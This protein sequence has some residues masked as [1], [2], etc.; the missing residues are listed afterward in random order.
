ML[1]E[2]ITLTGTPIENSLTDLW[3]QINFVNRGLLGNFNYFKNEF[4]TPIEK[5]KNQSQ[6]EKLKSLIHPFVLRRT[7]DQ[8]AK[9][10]P[11]KTEQFRICEMDEKQQKIYEEEK[12]VVR[13]SIIDSME[14]QGVGKSS[15][16]VL[17]SLMRLRQLANS[18]NFV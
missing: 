3:S 5:F 14:S 12:S 7:K 4:V 11:P 17:K 1:Y 10:L 18:Y 2:V 9:D 15:M 6:S 8:V 16:L 13:N